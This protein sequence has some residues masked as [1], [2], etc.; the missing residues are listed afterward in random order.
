MHGHVDLVSLLLDSG[1][2]LD[3]F[4]RKKG[5]TPLHEAVESQQASIV[6]LLL[7]SG[8]CDPDVKDVKGNTP[9]H[10]AACLGDARLIEVLLKASP[11]IKLKNKTGRTALDEAEQ[12]T[13]LTVARLI[14][15][16]PFELSG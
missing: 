16:R 1:A 8:R 12:R 3:I 13:F 2:R 15:G 9:L 4:S 5:Y 14:R 11:D 6:R 7:R 10:L